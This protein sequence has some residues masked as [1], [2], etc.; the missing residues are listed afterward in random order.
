MKRILYTALISACAVPAFATDVGVSINIGEPGFYGQIDIGNAP[1][2]RLVYAQPVVIQ[3]SPEFV[4][5]QPIYLHVRPGHEK[6][7]R[8]HCAEYNAC[9]RPVYFV[10]DD[11]YNNEYVPRYQRGD[12]DHGGGHEHDRGHDRDHGHDEEHG[13]HEEHGHD[14]GHGHQ[15]RHGHDED[16]GHH[17]R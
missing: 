14:E 16:H 2:P 8:R 15:E 11:W 12:G 1:Q 9:G 13:H 4:S 10:R 3:R 6:H 5:V 7:W 17:D